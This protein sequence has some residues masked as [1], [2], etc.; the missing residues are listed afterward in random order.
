MKIQTFNNGK[1]LIHGSDPKRIGCDIG[2]VLKIGKTEIVISTDAE[3]VMPVLFN[4]CTGIYSATFTSVAGI[5]YE[6]DK[7][8]VR[9]GRIAPP[10]QTSVELMELRCRVEETES[11]CATLEQKNRELSNI[12]DTDSLNFLIK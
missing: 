10:S 5:V 8:A 3:S 7:V 6:L 4:G 2:G 11:R 9:N 1:G 12:F